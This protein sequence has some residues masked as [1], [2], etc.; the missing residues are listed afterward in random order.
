MR[1]TRIALSTFGA[2]FALGLGVDAF[3]PGPLDRVASGLMA[4]GLLGIP[5]GLAVDLWLAIRT[6][7]RAAKKPA[8]TP[9][10]RTA[11]ARPRRATRSRR[12]AVPKR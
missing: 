9:T 12:P 4:L 3:A 2:G 5:V 7:A 6:G 10:R 11:A 1:Y 8:K